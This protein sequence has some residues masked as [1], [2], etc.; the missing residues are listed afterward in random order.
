M[1]GMYVPTIGHLIPAG[2]TAMR[3]AIHL[4]VAPVEAGEDLSPGSVV[5]LH[6][7]KAYSTILAMAVGVVDPFLPATV[8][9]GEVFW[10]FVC[11]NTITSLRHVWQHPAFGMVPG[12]THPGEVV[13]DRCPFL[14]RGHRCLLRDG[15]TGDHRYA[16]DAA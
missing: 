1:S 3:D 2:Q 14:Y 9:K 6:N 4:P 10:L 7:G 13:S 12:A 5:K 11:P 8:R 16:G 15:H